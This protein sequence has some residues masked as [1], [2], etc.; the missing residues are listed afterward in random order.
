MR[1]KIMRTMLLLRWLRMTFSLTET[2]N[3]ERFE[4]WSTHD[5]RQPIRSGVLL[6]L[7]YN[8]DFCIIVPLIVKFFCPR[9][10]GYERMDSSGL[11]ETRQQLHL[12]KDGDFLIILA[13]A[14]K[15]RPRIYM[16][17]LGEGGQNGTETIFRNVLGCL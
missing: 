2:E 3:V 17:A 10:F 11:Q 15:L 9:K 14:E 16:C 8:A 4:K 1:H 5:R 12:T 7:G 6:N 13:Q